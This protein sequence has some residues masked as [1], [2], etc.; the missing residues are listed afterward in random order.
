[1][2]RS[3]KKCLVASVAT[4]AL[5][6]TILIFGPAFLVSHDK[7][8]DMPVLDVIPSKL[9][10]EAAFGGGNPKAQ[11]PPPA[12]QPA[13]AKPEPE[14]VPPQP[15]PKPPEPVKQPTPE[16]VKEIKHSEESAEANEKPSLKP[17]KHKIEISTEL[18]KRKPNST[19]KK[20]TTSSDAEAQAEKRAKEAAR[21]AFNRAVRSLRDGLSSSTTVDP[22]GPG[23]EAYA[24]YAQV[25]KSIYEHA[26]IAPED[27]TDN[28]GTTKAS[29]TIA[30]DGTVIS[31]RVIRSSGDSAVDRSVERTLERVKF[32]AV[33]PE[34]AKEARR[35]FTINF[36]LKAKRLLG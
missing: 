28:D 21:M 13:L 6:L 8:T 3:Q 34:G 27:A 12:P 24:N 25:V 2:N 10:D 32:V 17:L 14:P 31:A 15:Q 29:V 11:P 26:W 16:P 5:L 1:M 36:N 7:M 33:F 19:S 35:T 9:I 23:G 20:T 4:H 22:P 30:R 18:V